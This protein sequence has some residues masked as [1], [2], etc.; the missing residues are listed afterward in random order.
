[1]PIPQDFSEFFSAFGAPATA[2]ALAVGLVRGARA[3]ESDAN[4]DALKYVAGLLTAGDLASF[5]KLGPTVIPFIFEGVF[6]R[7]P[8]SFR[9]I[10]CL[11]G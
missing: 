1:M 4:P 10:P 7:N 2:M 11:S 9:F 3:L 6:G 8:L 5:G